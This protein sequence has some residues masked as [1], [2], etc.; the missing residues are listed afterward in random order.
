MPDEVVIFGEVTTLRIAVERHLKAKS[1]SPVTINFRGDVFRCLFKKKGSFRDGWQLLDTSAFPTK[2]FPIFWDHC[3]DSHGQG[4]KVLY[5]MKVKHFI[6]WSPKKYSVGE[7]HYPSPRAFQEK[8]TF[9]FI[10]VALGD[11]S[12]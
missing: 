5:P 3:A 9:L 8:L 7:G 1:R 11:S 6:S 2:Y 4:I 10:R 12:E